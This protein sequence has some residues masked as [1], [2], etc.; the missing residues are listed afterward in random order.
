MSNHSV[1][2]VGLGYIGLPTAVIM[3]NH[4]LD[5]HGFDINEQAVDAINS[6]E[7]TIV[8]PGLKQKLRQVLDSGCFRAS[9]EPRHSD[10]FVI[11]VPTPCTETKEGDLSYIFSA[12]EKIAPLLRG[13]E[14]IILESTSPPQTTQ[15]LAQYILSLR[16]DLC[17]DGAPNPQGLPVI[18]FAHC[19][20][21]ILPGRALEELVTNDRI[22]G[23]QSPR[24]IEKACEL[25]RTFCTGELLETDDVTAELAKLTENSFRD[26]NIAFAN[27]LSLIA[28]SLGVDVWELIDLANH[29]PRV[30]ILQ[31]GPGVGG[32][33]IAVDP[34]FIVS[35]DPKNSPLIRTAREVNDRKP[36]WV[37]E[38]VKSAVAR[39]DSARIAVLGLS[40]KADIDDLRESAALK[41]AQ[42]LAQELPH[43]SLTVVEP[44]I[45]ELPSVLRDYPQVHL[46]SLEDA[47]ADANIVLLLVDHQAFSLVPACA[48]A[49]KE[50]I[51][52]KGFWR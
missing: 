28:E 22:I 26:V 3:A 47:L 44:H 1:T 21:R 49:G 10:T 37:I 52:T 18:Y 16:P 30:N 5:V 33:C 48:L 8:E 27:E 34:W 40:F 7:L 13:G 50:V 12:G 11:A 42:Q 35:S 41:I 39:V 38:Q 29:H 45:S 32:H 14:L 15:K 31:P 19:P 6:G 43:S 2:F 24:A 17:A 36:Q 46:A 20:E 51:D 25:Y 9:T 23:G 4:G